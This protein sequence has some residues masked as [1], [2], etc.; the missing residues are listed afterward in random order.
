MTREEFFKEAQKLADSNKSAWPKA[1]IDIL[2]GAVR[3]LSRVW[4]AEQVSNAILTG[5]WEYVFLKPINAEKN[6][7]AMERYA[8]EEV[9]RQKIDDE[10]CKGEG[11][12][13]ILKEHKIKSVTE[14]FDIKKSEN[15]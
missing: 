15:G 10:V 2:W 4:F 13:S 12:R 9:E 3:G 14:I 6:R 11:L 8:K 5:G 7:V 1:K